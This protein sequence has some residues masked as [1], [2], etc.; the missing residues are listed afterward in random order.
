MECWSGDQFYFF[1]DDAAVHVPLASPHLILR[2]NDN[3]GGRMH[4][5]LTP[6]SFLATYDAKDMQS[7]ASPVPSCHVLGLFPGTGTGTD[8]PFLSG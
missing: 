1:N 5:A 2:R 6:S 3:L 7:R 8:V 4:N